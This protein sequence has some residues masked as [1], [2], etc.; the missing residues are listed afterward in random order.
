MKLRIVEEKSLQEADYKEEFINAGRAYE[1]GFTEEDA[2][3]QQLAMGIEVEME[4]T[5]N[6]EIAKRIAEDHLAEIKDYY[7][8]LKRME[9]EGKAEGMDVKPEELKNAKKNKPTAE[10]GNE[11]ADKDKEDDDSADDKKDTKKVAGETSLKV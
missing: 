9:E 10:K 5:T 2:I 11:S 3:A 8:R 1:I 7:S 6:R 4:H